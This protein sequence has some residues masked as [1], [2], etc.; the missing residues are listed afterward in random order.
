VTLSKYDEEDD[1]LENYFE[2]MGDDEYMEKV[3]KLTE[4]VE[5]K[6]RL[7]KEIERNA[8]LSDKDKAF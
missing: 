8:M 3:T 6:K 1:S 5:A 7:R 2:G 4:K